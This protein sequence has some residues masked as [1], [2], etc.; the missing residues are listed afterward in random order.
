MPDGSASHNRKNPYSC[1]HTVEMWSRLWTE[2]EKVDR[3]KLIHCGYVAELFCL[4][5]FIS[6]NIARA[7]IFIGCLSYH[8]QERSDFRSE[9]AMARMNYIQASS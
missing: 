7:R 3:E 5:A 6:H 1:A 4:L 9:R 2:A 8:L